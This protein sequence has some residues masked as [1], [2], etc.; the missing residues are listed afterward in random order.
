MLYRSLSFAPGHHGNYLV[1]AAFFYGNLRIIVQIVLFLVCQAAIA[2]AFPPAAE[3]VPL[4]QF[5]ILAGV[6]LE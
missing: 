2:E 1:Y 5:C 3:D 6:Y 4:I